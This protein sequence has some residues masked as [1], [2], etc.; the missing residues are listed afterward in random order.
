MLLALI[1]KIKRLND[2]QIWVE[3]CM[4]IIKKRR[5]LNNGR[6]EINIR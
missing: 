4:G 1:S 2:I 3:R 5:K 6:M